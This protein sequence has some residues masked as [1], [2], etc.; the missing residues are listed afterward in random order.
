MPAA[1]ETQARVYL[2]AQACARFVLASDIAAA[3]EVIVDGES[4]AIHRAGDVEDLAQKTLRA[5]SDARWRSEIGRRARTR[6]QEGH[7]MNAA[8]TA[9]L[10]QFA[11][12]TA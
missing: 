9:Y 2:E 7:D 6:V 8:V 11:R 3:R 12:L 5:A 1:W 4:G 10:D